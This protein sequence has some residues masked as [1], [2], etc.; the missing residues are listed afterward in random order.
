MSVKAY[1]FHKAKHLLL[2][3]FFYLVL[4]TL[5]Q[6]TITLINTHHFK[7]EVSFLDLFLG[8]NGLTGVYLVFWFITTLFAVQIIYC[9][10]DRMK[11]HI[12]IILVLF[13]YLAAHIESHYWH[14]IQIPWDLDVSLYA[15]IFYTIGD[16]YHRSKL[17]IKSSFIPWATLPAMIFLIV[18]V[19]LYTKGIL[20]FH[21]DLK[22][23]IYN[24]L[25]ADLLVPL[26]IILILIY[27]S[28]LLDRFR[29]VSILLTYIGRASMVIMYLHVFSALFAAQFLNQS[30]LIFF[31]TGITFPL[32][33]YEL[34]SR[35]NA[36]SF[37]RD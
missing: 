12:K 24:H 15:I 7:M 4:I 5:M 25:L 26:S 29:M 33:F 8:G 17:T 10:L 3:Y 32:I 6:I 35:I 1:T 11:L 13:A 2:P 19:V 27:L 30:P 21:L 34:V 36:L 28:S 31:I 23:H 9:F 14:L 16:L 18:F 20:A 22:Q 37:L